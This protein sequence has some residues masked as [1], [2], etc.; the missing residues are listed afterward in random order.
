MRFKT[1]MAVS[2]TIWAGGILGAPMVQAACEGAPAAV[3][4]SEWFHTSTKIGGYC[5]YVVFSNGRAERDFSCNSG[6]HV[7]LVR[8]GK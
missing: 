4:R 2:A 3:S 6:T 1:V 8:D 5:W 7:R